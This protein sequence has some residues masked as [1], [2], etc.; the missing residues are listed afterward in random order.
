VAGLGVTYVLSKV[1]KEN[2]SVM[3]RSMAGLFLLLVLGIMCTL[4]VKQAAIWKDSMTLWSTELKIFP[5]SSKA[6]FTI[7][8]YHYDK[9]STAKAV[10]YFNRAIEI[11]PLYARAYYDR[12]LA[13]E[14]SGNYQLALRDYS[15]AISA[16]PGY[17]LAYINRGVL[18]ARRGKYQNAITDFS[19][20]IVL[21]PK[22]PF[23]FYNRGLVYELSGNRKDA[24]NDF[25]VA[26]KLGNN[27]SQ[28]RLKMKSMIR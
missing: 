23:A 7:G 1:R 21:N 16:N 28:N 20:G 27:E 15:M 17:Q 13:Y 3:W 22:D 5:D 25:Q 24:Y 14:D 26:A 12:A 9:G 11:D 18:H 19:R 8:N 10:E 2:A 6:Y 4:T